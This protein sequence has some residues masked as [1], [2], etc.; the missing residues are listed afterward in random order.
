MKKLYFLLL[1]ALGL[2]LSLCPLQSQAT[3]TLA[4]QATAEQILDSNKS[5]PDYKALHTLI[6]NKN[7]P[8]MWVITGDSITHGCLHTKG[9]RSYPELW[10]ERVKWELRRI[11][12]IV[13]NTGV[14]GDTSDGVL[15]QFDWR[16]G[17]FSPQVVSVNFGVN[18]VTKLGNCNTV[19][20]KK[21]L[22]TIVANIRKI[23]AIPVLQVPSHIDA[24]AGVRYTNLPKFNQIVR[25]VA[26]DKKV[27]LVDNDEHW[28][29]YA[30]SPE[31]EKSWRNDSLHPNGIGHA[32]MFK[33]MAYELGL[34]DSK[35]PA[36]QA[37]NK[38]L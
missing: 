26:K 18:D 32:E 8:I 24:S 15:K 36:C 25:Q 9:Q 35:S 12:D 33:I 29:R 14:S 3:P 7:K 27:L 5:L 19:A 17:Q 21:N 4:P 11:N 30:K 13:V 2:A 1:S 6:A 16:I 22:E 34:F 23:K 20:F 38:T 28:T 10:M 31:I 37:G